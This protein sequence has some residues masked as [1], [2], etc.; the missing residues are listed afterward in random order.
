MISVLILTQ[1]CNL[2][3]STSGISPYCNGTCAVITSLC[4][5]IS[6]L[7]LLV[8][9][10]Y[11]LGYVKW[12]SKPDNRNACLFHLLLFHPF[13]MVSLIFPCFNW[14]LFLRDVPVIINYIISIM[15]GF[16]DILT[17]LLS[18]QRIISVIVHKICHKNII[19]T[20]L[21]CFI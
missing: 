13:F 11:E 14:V 1:G 12:G 3:T 18:H 16:F 15:Q 5:Y 6:S 8:K 7:D 2:P 9:R 10:N 17:L 21:F 4:S 19:F 20:K